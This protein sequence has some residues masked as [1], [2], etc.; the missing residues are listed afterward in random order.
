VLNRTSLS[1]ILPEPQQV[2][3]TVYDMLGRLIREEHLALQGGK[4]NWVWQGEGTNGQRVPAGVYFMRIASTDL[5]V[6]RK[7]LLLNP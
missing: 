4:H 6:T 7:L 2:S 5:N 1:L 3:I